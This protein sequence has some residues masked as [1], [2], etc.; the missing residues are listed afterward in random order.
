MS[1]YETKSSNKITAFQLHSFVLYCWNDQTKSTRVHL[2]LSEQLLYEGWH[3]AHWECYPC[4]LVLGNLP[5]QTERM[6]KLLCG[7][8]GLHFVI[9]INKIHHAKMIPF[10]AINI[11]I[12]KEQYRILTTLISKV[13]RGKSIYNEGFSPF[14]QY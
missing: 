3:R 13:G 4:D 14:L 5:L 2:L 9:A 10:S 7:T 1:L 6:T 8:S 12:C 11:W